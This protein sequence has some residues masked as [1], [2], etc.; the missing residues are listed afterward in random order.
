LNEATL[1]STLSV[2]LAGTAADGSAVTS[3]PGSQVIWVDAGD[4]VL[5][6]LD[7]VQT[8]ILD[9]LVL[10]SLDLETDQT[11]RTPLVVP[12]ALGS[13][14]D[15]AGLIATTEE[16]PRGDGALAAR[17]GEATQA[18]AWSAFLQMAQGH[19]SER[20]KL[21]G[22]ISAKTGTLTFHADDP[23]TPALVTA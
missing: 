8:R 9:R 23:A 18:A 21:P 6:H 4:E 2:H 5:V 13:A 12:F 17:W 1:S 15:S 11:G 22:G 7:S 14:D 16:F 20:G 10:V 19:A 3:V